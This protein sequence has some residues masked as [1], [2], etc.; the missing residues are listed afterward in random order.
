MGYTEQEYVEK[1]EDLKNGQYDAIKAYNQTKD[2][3]VDLNKERVDEI[4]NI[5]NK[6]IEAFEKLTQAK[7]KEL[8]SEKD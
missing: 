8:D 5:I 3:I 2:A 6:E 1:L 7:K 4:K